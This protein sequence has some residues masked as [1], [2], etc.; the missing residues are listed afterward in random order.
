[1]YKI[2]MTKSFRK[3]TERCQKRGYNKFVDN[4]KARMGDEG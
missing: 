1:M 4:M 3:D 2:R